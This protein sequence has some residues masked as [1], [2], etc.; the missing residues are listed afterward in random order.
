M[1][2]QDVGHAAEPF[3]MPVELGKIREF[4]NATKSTHIAYDGEVDETPLTPV[5]FLMTSSWWQRP[6]N[7]PLESLGLD[8][9]RMLHGGQEFIFH[10]E[11]P[12]AGD[13]LRGCARIDKRY[14]KMGKRG[15]AMTFLEIVVAFSNGEGRLIAETRST[16][17]ETSKF[18][19]ETS[20]E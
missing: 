8:R 19:T 10:G 14:T 3:T 20:H 9:S 16:I 7:N 17:I 4:A 15:G 13:V 6:Q 12:R 5:T 1:N 11:P 18:T 2:D